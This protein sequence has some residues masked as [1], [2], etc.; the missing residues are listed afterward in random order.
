MKKIKTQQLTKTQIKQKFTS[1]ID[2]LATKGGTIE[3][4][5]RGKIIAVMLNYRDYML[6]LAQSDVPHKSKFLLCESAELVGD[7]EAAI[8]DVSRLMRESVKNTAA[9]L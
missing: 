5:D 2:S 7:L 6:L 1:L 4:I 9:Q 3:I 8:K